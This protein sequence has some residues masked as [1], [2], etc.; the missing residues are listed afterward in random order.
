MAPAASRLPP[1]SQSPWKP[2]SIAPM[3]RAPSATLKTSTSDQNFRLSSVLAADS[4]GMSTDGASSRS[5]SDSSSANG[6]SSS[7][8]ETAWCGRKA[9]LVLEGVA[10]GHGVRAFEPRERILR[11]VEY[12][13]VVCVVG[14][15]AVS[16]VVALGQLWD[17]VVAMPVARCVVSHVCHLE[18]WYGVTWY[19]PSPRVRICRA[20]GRVFR[21][22]R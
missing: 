21:V 20:E 5:A 15:D 8:T 10:Q 2:T 18:V 16:C 7:T 13:P 9:L 17:V 11:V 3:L 6:T 14:F 12:D 22:D 4:S 19:K 1:T